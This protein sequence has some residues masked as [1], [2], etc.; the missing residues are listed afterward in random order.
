MQI[1]AKFYDD[2]PERYLLAFVDGH[3]GQHD[4]L[5]VR[6]DAETFL[7]AALDLGECVACVEAQLRSR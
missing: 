1:I 5:R 4:L 3:L 2:H 6:T 7:L